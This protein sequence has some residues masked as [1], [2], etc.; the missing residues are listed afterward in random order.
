[1]NT[2]KV[3]YTGPR[4]TPEPFEAQLPPPKPIPPG[5]A[6]PHLKLQDWE[7]PK[8]QQNRHKKAKGKQ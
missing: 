2:H 7:R 3:A 8:V 6:V 1:M 5:C 4:M